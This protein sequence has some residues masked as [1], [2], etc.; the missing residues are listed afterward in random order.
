MGLLVQLRSSEVVV[1]LDTEKVSK[2]DLS[3]S[4]LILNLVEKVTCDGA[5]HTW[6]QPFSSLSLKMTCFFSCLQCHLKFTLS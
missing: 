6:V 4:E 5:V 1:A 3:G 2:C